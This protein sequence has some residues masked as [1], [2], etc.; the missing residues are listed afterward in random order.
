[1]TNPPV[2]S[3]VS[4]NRQ[5]RFRWLACLL[6]VVLISISLMGFWL[7]NS[8]SGL[9]WAFSVIHRLSS[10]AIHFVGVRGTLHDMRI[11]NAHF[12]NNEFELVMQ[13]IRIAWNPSDLF[14]KKLTV[15]EL[16]TETLK[17]HQ[18]TSGDDTTTSALP[19]TL[20]LPFAL[21]VRALIINSV[22]LTTA[23]NGNVESIITNL[24]L[25]LES[26]GQTHQLR[27]LNFHTPWATF[28]ALAEIN[29][30]SPFDL[31][32]Q[33]E[34]SG[35]DPW[36]DAQMSIT[37]NLEQ[38]MI[39][40]SAAQPA[41]TR[42]LQIHLRPYAVNPVAL[43]DAT[44]EQLNPASFLSDAPNA[45]LSLFAHLTQ[46]D[47]GQLEGNIRVENHAA[48]TIDNN[49]L[50][51][52]TISTHALITAELLK[53]QDIRAQIGIE[54]YLHGN[55]AWHWVEQSASADLT[56]EQLNPRHIDSRLQAAQVSGKI[57][58][59]GNAET[60]SAHILL[61][62]KSIKLTAA[63]ART[64]ENVALEQFNLQRN[65]SQLTGQGKFAL[66]H[67]Q[68][69]ELSGKL[70]NFNLADFVQ[71]TDSNLNAT[72]QLS[73]QLSP[74]ISG[75][76]KYTIHNS[77]LAKSSIS[78]SG[79]VAFNGLDKFNGKAEL[80][81]GSNHLLV[82]GSIGDAK[83]AFHLTINA[84][85]LTQLGFGLAGDVHASMSIGGSFEAPDLDLKFSSKHL[86]L[87]ENQSISGVTAD[88]RLHNDAISL[89]VLID[90]YNAH[91]K[92]VI[93][94]LAIDTQGKISNH[95]LSIRALINEDIT[96]RLAATGGADPKMSR[97]SLRWNGQLTEFSTAGKMPIH[98]M[99]PAALSGSAE[100]ISLDQAKFSISGGF[101][102]IDQLHWTPKIWK[103]QGDFSGIALLPGSQ[104]VFNQLQLKLGG[105]W[106]FDSTAQLV[107]SLKIFREQGDWYL[108][109]EV[110]QPL[111]LEKLQLKA[112]AEHGE[113]IGKFELFSQ[114]VGSVSA[115]LLLPLQPSNMN[116]P[117]SR[118]SA[119]HGKVNMDIST[120]KWLSAMLGESIHVD[121]K[122]QVEADIQGTLEQP[123]FSG[124]VSGREMNVALL[125]QGIN[126]QQGTLAARF[127]QTDLKIDRL[128]FI[129]PHES[130]PDKRLFKKFES[131]GRSG[132][133]TING[134]IGLIG[135]ESQIDFTI[136]QL[137]LGHKNEYWVI[138][139]G[140]GVTR[141]QNNRLS[142][143][144]ELWADAGLLLQPP[145][146]RPEL[147]E[148]IVFV[149]A[150]NQPSQN[151]SISLDM[152]LNLGEKFHIRASGLEGRL[153]GQ[154]QVQNDRNNKLKLNGAIAAQDTS[155]KAYGQNLSVKRGIVSFQGPLDDPELNI[156]AVRENLAVVAGVEIMGSVRHPRVKLI[157]TP[158]V[159]DTEK[160]SWIVLGRKPDASGLD[161]SVLLAAAGSILGGQ[162][163]SGITEQISAALG[164]DEISFRQAGIGSSLTGQIGVVGK[165]ISS[166]AY[167]SYERGLTATTMGI[168]KL[169]Y[170]LTPKVTIVTQAGEDSAVDLF[171]TIQFD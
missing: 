133:L 25:T 57:H 163:G 21:S 23:D 28:N 97:K 59:S 118:E 107:G 89:K 17:I 171:Y 131:E 92:A 52:S 4:E 55:L 42:D 68:L 45:S 154:L 115:D 22:H 30:N 53:L 35:A 160:L 162:S 83:N 62:D 64:G 94:H 142:V 90:H 109:G 87:A 88:V 76:L 143:K 165:R 12:A 60:Q 38:M 7:M 18:L 125:D 63:I 93:K 5:K 155:F 111:G 71:T 65:K 104:Q 79:E 40:I 77:R 100:M 91:E 2:D 74:Q 164:V 151:L 13:N 50:P 81:A 3:Q 41:I 137:P 75:I 157:S 110:P 161:T 8:Q 140:S 113:L 101:V 47:S 124:M 49:G 150:T 33:I 168:T 6:F 37:G 96:V 43:L 132:S 123:N 24:S 135:K 16:S 141:F 103:T 122:I 82:R 72:L 20:D 95:S 39:Q 149:N 1:M 152:N 34:A 147:S 78:G 31:S 51:V 9:Q 136:N 169:T 145:E 170:N 44:I 116:G 56:V 54:G 112:T 67:E 134:N 36:G 139:S 158:D 159:P 114:S 11:E 156:L 129:T 130:P 29:G 105:H 102:N 106:N 127:Q 120:L 48:A 27:S 58:L 138:A 119:L 69:F 117:V 80:K 128:Q 61:K 15:E 70:A 153:T 26:D 66:G 121:G 166:R 126:L 32:A 167:L 14:Y 144:G 19:E 148:D 10:G 146:G 85:D 108:P 99:A 98:L 73:G 86:H 84:S 46:N